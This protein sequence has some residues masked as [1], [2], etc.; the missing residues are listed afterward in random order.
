MLLL[1][2]AGIW[3]AVAVGFFR[4]RMETTRVDSIVDFRRQLRVLQRTRPSRGLGVLEYPERT[5][6]VDD[7]LGRAALGPGPEHRRDQDNSPDHSKDEQYHDS[8]RSS[9]Y[10][11]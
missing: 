11:L 2:L 10:L 9:T 7:G 1:I 3:V 4:S 5:A 6:E 8:Q